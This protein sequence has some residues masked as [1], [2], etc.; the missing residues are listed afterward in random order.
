LIPTFAVLVVSG[1]AGTKPCL[2]IPAQIELARDVRD[3]AMRTRDDKRT[4]YERWV[5]N[6]DQSRTKLDRL[7]EERDQLKKEVS[8]SSS[9]GTQKTEEKKK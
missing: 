5:Q 7:T 1:C 3:A 6:V 8:G 2:V 9:E 4:E